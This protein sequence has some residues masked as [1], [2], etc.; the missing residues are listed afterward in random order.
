MNLKTDITKEAWLELDLL[1][2]VSRSYRKPHYDP[3]LVFQPTK[4]FLSGI[5]KELKKQCYV[6]QN[7]QDEFA[8]LCNKERYEALRNRIRNLDYRLRAP[9]G[10]NTKTLTDYDKECAKQ[11]PISS[12]YTNGTLKRQGANY[13]GLCPFHPDKHPSF[14]IYQDGKRFKC[15]S[16]GAEGDTI[17][18]VM[19]SNNLEFHEAI[20]L[21]LM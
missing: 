19:R 2:E 12:Y 18:F 14:S 17:D 6:Y 10:Q 13:T 3:F 5:S 21:I 7:E 1:E 8:K 4:S 15:F 20:K 9:N 11:Y 16:C